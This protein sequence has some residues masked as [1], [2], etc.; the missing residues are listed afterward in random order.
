MRIEITQE[1]IDA[2]LNRAMSPLDCIIFHALRDLGLD[3]QRVGFEGVKIGGEYYQLP[4]EVEQWQVAIWRQAEDDDAR[5]D[6]VHID[7]DKLTV[8]PSPI[9]F[10]LDVPE[11]ASQ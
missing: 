3:V 7:V 9:A 10:D 2:H 6:G 11:P 4:A 1:L 8:K 5:P